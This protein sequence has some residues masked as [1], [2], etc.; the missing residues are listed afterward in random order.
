MTRRPD[1]DRIAAAKR[2]PSELPDPLDMSWA[3][4]L[5]PTTGPD[6]RQALLASLSPAM[7]EGVAAWDRR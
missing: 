3:K 1:P 2:A 5:A 6:Q 7:R 4:Y